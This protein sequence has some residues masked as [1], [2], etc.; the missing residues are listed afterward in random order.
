MTSDPQAASVPP[1]RVAIIGSAAGIAVTHLQA[2][3][4]L[5]GVQLAGMADVAAE[6]GA[7]RAREHGC[8]FYTDHRALLA[9]VRPDLA[10]I[11][12]PHPFH[13]VIAIDCFAA[14]AHVLVEKPLAVEVAEADAMIAAAERAGKILAVNFQQRFR[15]A[16]ERARDLIDS[17]EL[18]ELVRVL[19]VEPWFRTQAY[20]DSAAW[21]GTWKGEGGGV[22]MNQGPHPLDLLCHLAGSPKTVW[23][24]VRTLGHRMEC[25]DTA[26]AMLEYP[27]GAPGYLYFSTVEAGVQRRMQI[28]GDKAAIELVED[29][30][31]IYRFSEPLSTYR[32]TSQEMW[33]A[34]KAVAEQVQVPPG[35]GGGHL[36]VYRDLLSAIAEGRRPRADGREALMSLEL[37]NA[38]V[39]SSFAGRPTTLPLDRAAYSALLADLRAGKR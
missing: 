1:L 2:L 13:A 14:G 33:G 5:P 37:A 3:K 39:Y 20:Y 35:D 25:E 8:P 23:G 19:C 22:L 12:T 31:T 24:W 36:A 30:L 7:A 15:P 9:E 38:V 21:R 26:Q 32:A 11:T 18:G 34:P 6:A 28:I 17:G 27:N 10:V 16:I 4:Q 29:A